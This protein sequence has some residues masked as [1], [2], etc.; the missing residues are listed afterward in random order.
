VDLLGKTDPT[1]AHSP[2]RTGFWMLP[3]HMRWDY[4]HSIVAL[5]PDVVAEI[6]GPTPGDYSMIPS[7]RLPACPFGEQSRRLRARRQ[8]T[9]QRS[10]DAACRRRRAL[11]GLGEVPA[12]GGD[13]LADALVLGLERGVRKR[14][15]ARESRGIGGDAVVAD[16]RRAAAVLVLPRNRDRFV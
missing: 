2:P 12:L 16:P 9:R 1:I 13:G 6:F 4:R 3:G 14:D 8:H 11:T 7:C 5:R 10:S 15:F